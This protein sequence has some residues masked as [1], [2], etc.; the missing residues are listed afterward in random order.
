MHAVY[1]FDIEFIK[2]FC[3]HF[4]YMRNKNNSRQNRFNAEYFDTD[5]IIEK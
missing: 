5:A 1:D 4:E 2:I 3:I